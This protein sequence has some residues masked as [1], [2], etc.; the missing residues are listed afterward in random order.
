MA[1]VRAFLAA[2]ISL[3]VALIPATAGSLMSAKPIEVTMVGQMDVPCCPCCDAQDDFKSSAACAIKCIS[4]FPATLPAI[5]SLPHVIKVALPSIADDNL[6]GHE[7]SPP[8]HPPP[9]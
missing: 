5:I 9:V 4:Y 3:S 1:I 6:R 2:M 8:T 7:S